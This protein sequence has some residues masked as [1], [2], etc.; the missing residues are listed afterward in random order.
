MK[1]ITPKSASNAN[2]QMNLRYS[3]KELN[4]NKKFAVVNQH[5]VNQTMAFQQL[6]TVPLAQ[7]DLKI[8]AIVETKDEAEENFEEFVSLNANTVLEQESFSGIKVNSAPNM[9]NFVNSNAWRRRF[10]FV[11][12]SLKRMGKGEWVDYLKDLVVADKV[13]YDDEKPNKGQP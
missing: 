8:G 6:I 12:E 13:V 9:S 1:N 2:K 11:D 4:L 10:M 7:N 5:P 3:S